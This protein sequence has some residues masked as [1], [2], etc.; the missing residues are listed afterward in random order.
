MKNVQDGGEAIVQGF[1][2]LGIDYIMASPGS[3]WSPVWEALADQQASNRPGP[4]F[5]SC[6]HETLAVDRKSVV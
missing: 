5:L 2:S 1:R 4:T 6:A 3:E